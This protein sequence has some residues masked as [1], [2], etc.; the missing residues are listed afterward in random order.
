MFLYMHFLSTERSVTL[1]TLRPSNKWP[2]T[3]FSADS[4]Q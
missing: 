3:D 4:E 2:Q 1:V